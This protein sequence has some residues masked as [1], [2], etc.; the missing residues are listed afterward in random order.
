MRQTALI[1]LIDRAERNSEASP[2]LRLPVEIRTR[3]FA[4]VLGGNEYSV[5]KPKKKPV[6]A[7]EGQP[8]GEAHRNL[9]V[10]RVCTQIY[11]ETAT[12]PFTL[13]TFYAWPHMM[14]GWQETL[15]PGHRDALQTMRV[16]FPEASENIMNL[17]YFKG[18][19]RVVVCYT[20]D[21]RKDL[22]RVA[23]R[24]HLLAEKRELEV[25]FRRFG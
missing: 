10:Q 18:L 20:P 25:E 21:S 2:L 3:I 6:C 5:Y 1:F 15:I 7:I 11:S 14:H 9:Q 12:L 19:Q 16:N 4:Y 8:R 23:K 13:N 17:H 22:G 24:L